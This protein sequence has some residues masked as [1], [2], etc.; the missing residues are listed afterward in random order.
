MNLPSINLSP[1]VAARVLGLMLVAW[2]PFIS[3]AR[4]PSLLLFL[5][6]VW[7][8]WR[9]RIDFQALAIKRMGLV[10]LL[11]LIPVLLS[12]PTSFDPQGG[13]SV[14]AL[15]P[16]FYVVGLSLLQG[17]STPTGREWLQ[18][19]LLV[20]LLIW[21]ADGYI[22]F[23]F[24]RGLLGVSMS[25]DERI[26][27]FFADNLHLGLFLAVLLPV[28]L[29]RLAAERPW[30]ALLIIALTSF[31]VIM[32]GARSGVL[33][34]VLACITLL[35]RFTWRYRALMVMVL[36]S[37]LIAAL[38]FSPVI[39]DRYERFVSLGNQTGVS[40]FQKFDGA[41]SGRVIIWET[42]W[43][44]IRDRPLT[45]V[46]AK[47]FAEAYDRYAT[48]A[49]DPFRSGGGYTGGVYH[50]HQMYVSVAAESGVIG[51]AGLLA[52]IGLC[53]AWYF[54]AP[55]ERRRQAAPF[56]ASLVVIAFPLQSQP[57]LYTLWWF[58][59]VLLLLCAMLAALGNNN[60]SLHSG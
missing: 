20:V 4:L 51:F 42:A 32:N 50:A 59:I 29:W 1:D 43:Q 26:L 30:L 37:A 16:L 33:M 9:K 31:I 56:V 48:R 14:A 27:G 58:P 36:T 49:E 23:A 24:G 18:R 46:G 15:L 25:E 35:P 47:A 52:A 3:G 44:M 13:L 55:P 57:V 38:L 39:S 8:L 10:F 45:G 19:W 7:M 40:L 6:G 21:L 34:L 53:A 2:Q 22:Q 41:L 12:L 60:P 54:H 17:L 11:L 28:I 5:L